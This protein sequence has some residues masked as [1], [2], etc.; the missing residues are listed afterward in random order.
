[1]LSVTVSVLNRAKITKY[2][3]FY[4]SPSTQH[5]ESKQRNPLRL[6]RVCVE[7]RGLF[8]PNLVRCSRS[9]SEHA[10]GCTEHSEGGQAHRQPCQQ[11][12]RLLPH[13]FPVG[14]HDQN[15]DQ[16]KGS[17]ES[18]DDRRPVQRFH[19]AHVCEIEDDADQD[20]KNDYTIEWTSGV[21]SSV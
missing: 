15:A 19:G 18:V 5:G 16:E 1:M 13:D 4:P 2:K 7:R 12:T 3:A 21:K 17:D 11:R 20:G 9:K 6:V 8:S 14:G 10:N